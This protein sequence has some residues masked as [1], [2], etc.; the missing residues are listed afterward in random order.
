MSDSIS[1]THSIKLCA[2]KNEEKNEY[3]SGPTVKP[4]H[5]FFREITAVGHRV[6]QGGALFNKSMLVTDEVIKGIEEMCALAPLHN[7]ANIIG[8]N[9][10]ATNL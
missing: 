10:C 1:S 7:P 9:A 3:R 2:R 6:V 5:K 4:I 8:I